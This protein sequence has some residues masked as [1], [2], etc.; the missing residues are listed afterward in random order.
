MFGA[1]VFPPIPMRFAYKP[2]PADAMGSSSPAPST[3]SGSSSSE[4][5]APPYDTLS[6]FSMESSAALRPS[7][8]RL[9]AEAEWGLAAAAA[10][11]LQVPRPFATAPARRDRRQWDQRSRATAMCGAGFRHPTK[12]M[13]G[14]VSRPPP[15]DVMDVDSSAPST[16]SSDSSSSSM[17]TTPSPRVL[18]TA[19]KMMPPWSFPTEP[20]PRVEVRQVW[21]HNFDTEAE[22]IKSLLP[23][24]PYVAVDTEFPGTVY[25][26]AG[27]AYTLTPERRYEL[28]RQNVDALDLIQL[29]LTLF[30][31][32]GQ[33]PPCG[34]ATWY[35]WEFN[36]R[37]FD[38]RRHRHAPE[39]IAMLR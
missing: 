5:S 37:E 19:R 29:G 4:T 35:V 30:D 10:A 2:A 38:V 31:S 20:A 15:A 7:Q 32:A 8:Q 6:A 33:L 28:L 14:Y 17:E 9:M 34:G 26:P 27:A 12:T 22:L 24:F 23:N 16:P 36:F 13:L 3:P 39:S 18:A 25:R 1:P 11:A 21:A